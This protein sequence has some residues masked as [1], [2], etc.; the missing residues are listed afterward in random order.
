V[1]ENI[2]LHCIGTRESDD[3]SYTTPKN[4][5]IKDLPHAIL[6]ALS[7]FSRPFAS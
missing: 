6:S 5:V 7:C 1:G 2:A 3:F 4:E